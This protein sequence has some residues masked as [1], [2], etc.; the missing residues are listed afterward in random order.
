MESLLQCHVSMQRLF[1]AK[2]GPNDSLMCH[3]PIV[4]WIRLVTN[5]S[6]VCYL[7]PAIY[8][9]FQSTLK[10]STNLTFKD[11]VSN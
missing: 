3:S 1:S 4:Y 6:D 11:K 5:N 7:R 8:F 10:S 9:Y 2:V